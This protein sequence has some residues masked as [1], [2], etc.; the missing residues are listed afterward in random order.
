MKEQIRF[1]Q[2]GCGRMGSNTTKYAIEDGAKLVAAFDINPDIIGKDA[3]EIFGLGNVGV[4]I[5]DLSDADKILSELKPDI[6]IITTRSLMNEVKDILLICA[7]NGVNAITTCEEA[8]YPWNSSPGITKEIDALAKK[9]NCTITGTGA[10]EAQYGGIFGLYGGITHKTDRIVAKAL[11]NVDDY[12]IALAIGHG[13]GLT[14]EEFEREIASVDN[15]SEAERNLLIEKGEFLPSYVWNTN[16]WIC[17]YLGLTVK[18]QIQKCKPVF[19]DVDIES[20]TMGKVIEKGKAIGM[21]A[22]SITET[23]ENITIEAECVGIVYGQGEEDTNDSVTYGVPN[24]ECYFK[25]PDTVGMTCSVIVNR[26]PDVI[27]ARPGFVTTSQMPTLK[28]RAKPLHEYV[29]K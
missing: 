9:N 1:A 27:N 8:I 11:Y 4:D 29:I 7:K 12:G 15:I 17:D 16:G 21:A 6:C 26:I 28:Y 5:S 2:Y 18:S 3:G 25:N 24:T 19:A 10:N 23:E 20:K 13:V 22:V 14:A